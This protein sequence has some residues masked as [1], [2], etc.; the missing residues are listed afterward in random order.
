MNVLLLAPKVPFPPTDGGRAAT[1]QMVRELLRMGMDVQFVAP[2]G[3]ANDAEAF[4]REVHLHLLSVDPRTTLRGVLK[5]VP[6]RMPYQ[7]EKFFSPTALRELEGILR[8]KPPDLIHVENLQMVTYAFALKGGDGIPI[9]LR[10]QN[11]ESEIVRLYRQTVANPLLVSYAHHQYRRMARFEAEAIG[12]ADLVLPVSGVDEEKLRKMNPG[13]RSSV[14]PLGVD[15]DVLRRASSTVPDTVLVF[16]NMSWMP[17]RDSVEFFLEDIVPMLRKERPHTRVLLGGKGT[18][19]ERR[20][21][22]RADVEVCGFIED[23]NDLPG[24]SSVAAVPLRIGSGMRVKVLEFMALGMAV[25]STS[26]GVEGIDVEDGTHVLVA[27]TA[28]SFAGSIRKLLENPEKCRE[29]GVNARRLIEERYSLDA[30]GISL[31]AAYARLSPDLRG[32]N[33]GA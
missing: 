16:T 31:R 12:K 32:G 33:D 28:E 3:M 7:V 27:D 8:K 14:V 17:N 13:M 1:Y 23:L 5:N 30:V 21:H 9:V 25:V 15:T 24:L 22:A 2:R 6:H 19:S 18:D 20:L 10:Q 29:I 4:S 26:L 11:V